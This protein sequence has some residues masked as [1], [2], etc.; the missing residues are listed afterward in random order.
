[1]RTDRLRVAGP[2]RRMPA[3]ERSRVNWE[4]WLPAPV[5]VICA[6]LAPNAISSSRTW[7]A[8][9]RGQLYLASEGADVSGG[10]FKTG[11]AGGVGG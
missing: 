2:A 7:S 11:V 10:A 4:K 6:G 8:R 5:V 3:G 9:C 1:M